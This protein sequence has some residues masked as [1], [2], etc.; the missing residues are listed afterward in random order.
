MRIRRLL[1]G[2]AAS[3][4]LGLSVLAGVGAAPAY[5]HGDNSQEAFLRDRALGWL[6]V[7]LSKTAVKQGET[8]DVTGRVRIL[9][10]YPSKNV[11]A[12][13]IAYL[14]SV[15][16][17]ASLTVRDR[18]I[19]GVF[20]PQILQGLQIGATYP[21]KITLAG[22]LPGW[23]HVH[24]SIAVKGAGQMIGPGT[25]VHITKS[26]LGYKNEV[27]LYNGEKVN[28]ENAYITT[29]WFWHILMAL[30]GALLIAYWLIPRPIIWRAAYVSADPPPTGVEDFLIS[31][32]DHK[33]TY[34]FGAAALLI[35][36]A[37]AGYSS[38]AWPKQIPLQVR[39]TTPTP[40]PDPARFTTVKVNGA[41]WESAH[42]TVS[43]QMDV[44]NTGQSPVQLSSWHIAATT[45]VNKDVPDNLKPK[46]SSN[47]CP[48]GFSE[49]YCQV[50]GPF[51]F[52]LDNPSAIAPGESRSLT[53]TA[54]SHI[55]SERRLIPSQEAQTQMGGVLRFVDTNGNENL[56]DV[57]GELTLR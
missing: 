32:F 37:G 40:T 56:S 26:P 27:T 2:A 1:G 34:A 17:G 43:L 55:W 51:T 16:S 48:E 14:S 20:A 18:Q 21:F 11:P 12:P 46:L 4:L 13:D 41:T 31:K 6:D 36:I 7:Q 9:S 22:R 49:A 25:W 24:P 8:L 47:F 50:S 19:G 28:L 53:L 5:A 45:F 29:Q 30:P 35:T 15:H 33:V 42:E 38:S 23:Y 52:T 57:T 10:T 44:T 3:A 39:Y 54:S